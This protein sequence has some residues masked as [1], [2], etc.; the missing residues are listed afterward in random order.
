LVKDREIGRVEIR[1][2]APGL[3]LKDFL[4]FIIWLAAVASVFNKPTSGR[5]EDEQGD[6]YFHEFLDFLLIRPI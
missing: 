6:I 5:C 4:K 2:V 1:F 3:I